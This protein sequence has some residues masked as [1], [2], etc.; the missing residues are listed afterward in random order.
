MNPTI[1]NILAVIAGLLLGSILNMALVISGA[2]LIPVPSGADITTTEGLKASIHLFRPI[3]FLFPF[4]AHALGTLLG[5]FVAAMFATPA[6]K[7]S[8]SLLIGG[9]FL[10]GGLV[11]VMTLPSPLWFNLS[12]L[13]LAYIPMALIAYRIVAGRE[14]PGL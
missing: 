14:K 10:L 12:D 7:K 9:L 5:A 6:K 4:L 13:C 8:V 1:K 2:N 11:N 3:N